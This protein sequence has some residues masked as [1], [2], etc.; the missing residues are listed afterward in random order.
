MFGNDCG[1]LGMN[2]KVKVSI[3]CKRC[4]EKFVLRGRKEKGRIHTG[5]KKCICD[6]EDDFEIH[7]EDA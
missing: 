1:G 5:F 2:A 3:R 7:E 4:G 6:N